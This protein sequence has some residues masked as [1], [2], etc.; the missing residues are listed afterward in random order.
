MSLPEVRKLL[1]PF[2][3]IRIHVSDGKSYTIRH[4]EFFMLFAHK[5]IVA[6]PSRQPGVMANDFHIA[7]LHITTIE[8][9]RGKEKI[10][11]P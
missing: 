4:P 8:E 6:V 9:L 7:L 1:Y 5:L 11:K 3:P 10:A 2:R